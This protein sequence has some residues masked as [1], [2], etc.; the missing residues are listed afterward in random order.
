MKIQKSN[1]ALTLNKSTVTDLNYTQMNAA[2]GGYYNTRFDY[3]CVYWCGCGTNFF[4]CKT[5][6]SYC[7]TNYVLTNCCTEK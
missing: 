7:C 1:K 2:K 6:L 3:T 5:A 4:H